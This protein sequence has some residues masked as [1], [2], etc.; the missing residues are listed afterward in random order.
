MYRSFSKIMKS[1]LLPL[2]LFFFFLTAQ[3]W[4]D[5]AEIPFFLD[6]ANVGQVGDVHA[7]LC[8]YNRI[9]IIEVPTSNSSSFGSGL[10]RDIALI[11]SRVRE[12]VVRE[13]VVPLWEMIKDIDFRAAL[14]AALTPMLKERSWPHIIDLKQ[15]EGPLLTKKKDIL[16]KVTE[17]ALL[18]IYASHQ[19]TPNAEALKIGTAFV[20]YMKGNAKG[21]VKGICAYSSERIGKYEE[22]EEAIT[23]WAGSEGAAYRQALSQGIE[24]SVKM[25]NYALINAGGKSVLKS[26][27]TLHDLKIRTEYGEGSTDP[28]NEGNTVRGWIVEENEMRIIFRTNTGIFMSIPRSDIITLEKKQ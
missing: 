13:M 2:A 6:P 1:R 25:L 22:D 28:K 27:S 26:G 4:S 11:K 5:P 24:E 18:D 9:I 12:N 8:F 19:L 20:L 16:A 15:R 17:G 23:L 7:E 21:A 14:Q 10:G 3:S